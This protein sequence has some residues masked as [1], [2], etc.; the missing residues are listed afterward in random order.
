MIQTYGKEIN[1]QE[2]IYFDKKLRNR[3]KYSRNYILIQTY[4]LKRIQ[5]AKTKAFKLVFICALKLMLNH[6]YDQTNYSK[7]TLNSLWIQ[8]TKVHCR[9]S[10]TPYS[11]TS[12][13]SLNL[14]PNQG[15]PCKIGPVI[16]FSTS[17][18][19]KSFMVKS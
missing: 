8:Q 9:L 3:D 2:V 5:C 10:E 11:K 4:A 6:Y 19:F 1:I 7:K 13:G 16:T 18:I 14:S 15:R 17:L 12:P